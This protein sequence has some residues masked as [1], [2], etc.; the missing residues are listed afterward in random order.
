[1]NMKLPVRMAAYAALSFLIAG[2]GVREE[3]IV[4]A[5]VDVM[6]QVRSTLQN[7]VKGQPVTSEVTSYE[8]MVNELRKDSAEK[9]DILKAGLEEIKSSS[10]EALKS[11]AKALMQKLGLETGADK[12]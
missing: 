11:K 4:V 12:N 8:Y 3:T 5:K 6:N 10:G 9:A 2:C 1:M 7:Y